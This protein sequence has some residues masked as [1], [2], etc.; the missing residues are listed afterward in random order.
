MKISTCKQSV[1]RLVL[2]VV[3]ISIVAIAPVTVFAGQ[4]HQIYDI[5][6]IRNPSPH[7]TIIHIRTGHSVSYVWTYLGGRAVHGWLYSYG[8]SVQ[9]WQISFLSAD[10]SQSLL[11]KANC[12]LVTDSTYVSRSY[13]IGAGANYAAQRATVQMATTQQ[14]TTRATNTQ[15]P[16]ITPTVRN[17][18]NHRIDT[19]ITIF[20]RS[21]NPVIIENAIATWRNITINGDESFVRRTLDALAEIEAGPEWAY[22]YVTTYLSYIVQ[23]HNPGAHPRAGG[24]VNIRTR[25]FYVYTQTYTSRWSGWYASLIIHEAVHVRQYREHRETTPRTAF[26]SSH[27][28]R[29]AREI[30]AVEFQIRFLDDV[31]IT[32]TADMAR[33]IIRDIHN[34][35]FWW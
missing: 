24:R 19:T 21:G 35:I 4:R 34:G 11:I 3:F 33:R 32:N 14:Q 23:D 29:V 12:N 2:L 25:R 15:S 27:N 17:E 31:G 18:T 5:S 30:E 8:E 1:A 9:V 13:Q 16:A 6:E 22:I 10:I 20:N 7:H 28:A 26:P